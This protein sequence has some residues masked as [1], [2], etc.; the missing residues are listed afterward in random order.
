MADTEP[1]AAPAAA[2]G[3][4]GQTPKLDEVMLAMDVVDTLRHQEDLVEKEL[5]QGNRD[6]ALKARLRQLY[7]GQGL[8]V[9]DRILDEGIGALKE[10]RF[11]YT[12]PSP[13]F[14]RT[15]AL[16]W[17]RRASIAKV[18]LVL[19]AL[20]AVPLGRQIWSSRSERAAK[21]RARIELSSVL[22][23]ELSAA[24]E[25]TRNE[26]KVASAQEAVN[27]IAA[28]GRAALAAGNATEARAAI[29]Q[30]ADLRAK[31]VQQYALRIVSRP[32]ERTG[33]F[34]IPDVNQNT[35]NYYLIVEA[36]APDG[37]VLRMPILN[38]ENG[39][40]E[41]V[42]KWGVRVPQSTFDA[43]RRDKQDDGIVQNNLLGEKKRGA[44][45]PNYLMPVL[46][47]TITKW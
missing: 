20:A 44:L 34:R 28:D 30:L 24:V 40:T 8:E 43:V 21:E 3:A 10:S 12:P 25:V 42:T 37:K 6:E 33:F 9:S 13:S 41:T 5:G 19:L 39:K 4:T 14:A 2:S 15:M 31:L 16:L 7:E 26:A 27:T 22:P 17:V 23:G 11:V 18:G 35:R 38:E 29:S 1:S 36:I 47:G 45:K 46:G 32:G